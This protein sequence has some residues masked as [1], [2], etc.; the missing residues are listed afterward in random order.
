MFSEFLKSKVILV[1][2]GVFFAAELF[3]ASPIIINISNPNFRKLIVALPDLE[4]EGGA[5]DVEELAKSGPVELGQLLKFSGLFNVLDKTAY[6]KMDG[7]KSKNK[8]DKAATL[9][10]LEGVDLVQW[11]AIGVDSLTTGSIKKEAATFTLTLKTVDI[12]RGELVLGKVFSKV[13]KDQYSAVIRRYADLLLT[14][15]TGKPGI[16]S[17]KILFIGRKT[18][19][20]FKHVYTC[21]FDGSNVRQITN[22]NSTHLSAAWSYDGRYITF[23][24]YQDGNP[25]IFM[26]DRSTGLTKKLTGSGGLESGASWAPNG[27]LIIFTGSGAGDPDLFLIT[28]QGRNRKL[29][30]RGTGIDVDPAFSPNGKYLAYVSG[31]FGNPHI[32][33]AT[34]EWKGD[35]DVRVVTDQ[36]LTYVGWWNAVPAWSPESDKIAFAG[37]DK[38]INRF[39]IFIMNPDGR[40]LERLT[41]K[42]GDNENPSFSPNGQL[43]VFHSNRVKGRDEKGVNQLYVMN[44]D[45]GEQRMIFTGMYEAQTPKWGPSESYE[46]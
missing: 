29:F 1:V 16:F 27:K 34:L 2:A 8:N 33:N 10:G 6:P 31:R 23:T 20:A 41:I 21:D 7:E 18:K 44:R 28:P 30:I 4:A 26:F 35:T 45:G 39:D 9:K 24:S 13:T 17:S 32:F 11:K 36:R 40:N 15:Y 43:L 38:V 19:G 42:M 12:N 22:K 14:A 5:K 3:A 37:F 46:K 25:D